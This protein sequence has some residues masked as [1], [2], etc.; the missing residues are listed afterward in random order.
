[1]GRFVSQDPIGLN[2][3]NLLYQYALNPTVWADP[4]G[5][6][7][8]HIWTP[9][10]YR[11]VVKNAFEHFKKHGKEFP[12]LLNAKQY[13]ESA[14]SFINSPPPGTLI[15]VRANG[16]T[17]LYNPST[18]ILAVKDKDCTPKTMFK[19]DPSEHGYPTNLDYF[20]AQ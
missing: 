15:K 2:G 10:R 18:N 6:R 12:E 13:V 8:N 14:H 3:G 17:I 5:L 7:C 16:D 11:D 19:P 4:L 9:G 1:V 20:N